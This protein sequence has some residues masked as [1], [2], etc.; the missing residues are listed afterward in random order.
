VIAGSVFTGMFISSLL[1]V[2]PPWIYWV[3]LPLSVWIFYTLDHLV[4]ANR[5]KNYAHTHRH[6][7]V[8]RYFKPILML[9]TILSVVDILLVVI[10]LEKEVLM[11]GISIGFF[12][13]FY[14]FMIHLSGNKKFIVQQKEFF[15]TLIYTLGLWGVPVLLLDKGLSDVH[16]LCVIGFLILAYSNT[17]VFSFYETKTDKQD[18]HGSFAL[19]FGQ[20]KTRKIIVLLLFFVFLVAIYLIINNDEILVRVAAKIYMIMGLLSLA[21]VS[22][23]T[24]FKKERIYRLLTEVIF[25]VPGLIL[26]V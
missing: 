5:L 18:G 10:F 2:H 8:Y 1:D 20:D 22:F 25:W 7:F 6:L 24:L 17:L 26:L 9:V 3:V 4:D 12:A 23:P 11:Y 16:F 19:I 15:V 21:L 13:A 14:L